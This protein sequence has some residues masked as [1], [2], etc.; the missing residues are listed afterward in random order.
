MTEC[1]KL[2]FRFNT[3]SNNRNREKRRYLND[4]FHHMRVSAFFKGSTDKLHIK[5]E[6][7]DRQSGEHV[8]GGITGAEIVHLNTETKISEFA[9]RFDNLSRILRVGRFRHFEHK[10]GRR[11]T[12]FRKDVLQSAVYIGII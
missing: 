4:D 6:C 2:L 7:I 12:I 5:L 9:H 1:I 10:V 8:Q 11:K 3:L